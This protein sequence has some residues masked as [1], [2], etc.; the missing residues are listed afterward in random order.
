MRRQCVLRDICE[1]IGIVSLAPAVWYWRTVTVM[2]EAERRQRRSRRNRSAVRKVITST[3][4]GSRVLVRR[5]SFEFRFVSLHSTLFSVT[6]LLTFTSLSPFSYPC[7]F[8]FLEARSIEFTY[9]DILYEISR[10]LFLHMLIISQKLFY[11]FLFKRFTI[12][13]KSF[14]KF[15]KSILTISD[16]LTW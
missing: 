9:S 3:E 8:F 2:G 1:K 5:S 11:L 4:I 15:Q 13:F 14:F 7:R 16:P 10:F 6:P 12:F